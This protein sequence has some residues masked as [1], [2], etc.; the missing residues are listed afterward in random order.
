V[1]PAVLAALV[2][3]LAAGSAE[4]AT[5]VTGAEVLALA[6]AGLVAWWRRNLIASL[7]AGMVVLWVATWLT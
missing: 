1:G 7:V 6:V 5:G 4:G 3:S 2:V